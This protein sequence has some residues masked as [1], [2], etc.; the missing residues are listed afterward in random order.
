MKGSVADQQFAHYIRARDNGHLKWLEEAKKFDRFYE[1]DQWEDAD[2]NKLKNDGRPALTFNKVLSTVNAALGEHASRAMELTYK[3]KRNANREVAIVLSALANQIMHDNRYEFIENSVVADGLIMDRGY[4]DI[5][6][7]FSEHIQGEVK[8]TSVDPRTVLLDPDAKEYDPDTWNEVITTKWLTPDDIANIYGSSKVDKLKTAV[9]A[10]QF[11]T[12]DSVKFEEQ[13]FGDTDSTSTPD[14][15]LQ[16]REIRS[17]R[18]LERQYYRWQQ[19]MMFVDPRTGDMKPVPESWD[20]MRVDMFAQQNGLT[21]FKRPTRKVR[22]TV[23]ADDVVLYDEW[24]LYDKFTIVPYFPYFRRGRAFGMV[25]NLVSPQEALNKAR[26]QTLHIVNTTAN[27]GWTVEEGTLVNMT[28]DELEQRGAETGLVLIHARGS[29]PPQ[30]IQPN[31]VPTGLTNISNETEYSIQ[32]ISGINDGML[33][34][35]SDQV[36]GRMLDRKTERAQIQLQQPFKNLSLSRR[37]LGERL[38]ELIQNFYTEERVIQITHEDDPG[39]DDQEL[40]INTLDAAGQ[41]VND[42]TRGRYDVAIT[43][44]MAVDNQE[45]AEFQHMMDMRQHQIMLPDDVVLR[46]SPLRNREQIA[47]R[48]REMQ[49]AAEPSEQEAE[50]MMMQQQIAIETAQAELQKLQAQAEEIAT[51][52]ALNMAKAE[53]EAGGANAPEM[54]FKRDQLEAQIQMKKDELMTRIKLAELTHQ[55]KARSE[56]LRTLSDL[57]R[58]K[59]QAETQLESASMAKTQRDTGGKKN[60]G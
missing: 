26:S 34:M 2:L 27:S 49:G 22:W 8:I 37:L 19:Q 46:H 12:Y 43:T 28:E 44:R 25:R 55:N 3:P 10:G 58:T 39:K 31:S 13:R 32:A 17:V 5:R 21:L 42:V 38:L 56:Q 24:S 30:K 15:D 41:I 59:Y 51:K 23:T 20:E 4:F 29:N 40:V 35:T 6:I 48:V 53:Q 16:Q 11:R 52:S 9:R 45:E 60:G 14:V 1:G 7:D 47:E 50:M 54:E 57:T 33:G 18:V 36:S